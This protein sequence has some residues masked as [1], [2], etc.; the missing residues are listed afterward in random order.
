M[1]S[2]S[3]A[4]TASVPKRQSPSLATG[5]STGQSHLDGFRAMFHL[6]AGE[7][8]LVETWNAFLALRAAERMAELCSFEL[9]TLGKWI[10]RSEEAMATSNEET[11]SS[12]HWGYR[13]QDVLAELQRR[14]PFFSSEDSFKFSC[15]TI[16]ASALIGS[17]EKAASHVVTLQSFPCSQEQSWWALYTYKHVLLSLLRHS[18]PST[19]FEFYL[20]NRIALKRF[21][22]VGYSRGPRSLTSVGGPFFKELSAILRRIS[23]PAILLAQRGSQWDELLI[24]AAGRIMIHV[25]CQDNLAEDALAV[26][27]ELVRQDASV[28]YIHQHILVRA[29][30]KAGSFEHANTL[31]VAIEPKNKADEGEKRSYEST[32]LYLFAHQGDVGRA[33]DAFVRLFERKGVLSQ[34]MNLVMHASAVHG[35]VDRVLELFNAFFPQFSKESQNPVPSSRK[36]EPSVKHYSTVVYAFAQRN[37]F[38]GMNDWIR[39]MMK[40]GYTP[41]IVSFAQRGDISAI[42]SLLTHMYEVGIRP[43]IISYTT[44][45]KLLARRRDIVAAESMYKRMIRDGIVPDRKVITTVMNAYVE[46]GSWKGVIRVF[47]Y[48]RSMPTKHLKLGIDV[49]NTLLKAYVLVGAPLDIVMNI[50]RRLE[51]TNIRPTDRTFA[52]LIQSACDSGRMDVASRLFVEMETLA[53]NWQTNVQITVYALTI[54]MAGY[55]RQGLKAQARAVYDDMRKRGIQPTSYTLSSIMRAYANSNFDDNIHIAQEFLKSLMDAPAKG[56]SWAKP[57]AGRESSLALLYAPLMNAH[58]KNLNTEEVERLYSEFVDSEKRPSI[59]ILA[60]LLDVYRRTDNIKGRT[61]EVDMLLDGKDKESPLFRAQRRA[62]LLCIPLS[63]Y[64]DAVSRAGQHI[65]IAHTWNKLRDAGFQFDAH[66]WNHL[67]V[68]LVRAGQCVRAFEVVE[69]VIL[70]YQTEAQNVSRTRPVD[71]TSPLLSDDAEAVEEAGSEPFT[72]HSSRSYETRARWAQQQRE[73][74]LR[75]Q[76]ESDDYAHELQL[77]QQI[78]PAWNLTMNVL[79]NVLDR[80]GSGRLVN[81][82]KPVSTDRMAEA[83]AEATTKT[84]TGVG[85]QTQQSDSHIKP[86]ATQ[87]LRTEN[88]EVEA[89]HTG[90]RAARAMLDR[91]LRDYPQTNAVREES[92]QRTD[93]QTNRELRNRFGG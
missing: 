18:S 84:R 12:V 23:S 53:E 37:D 56:R 42:H 13:L 16:Q 3:V 44:A 58:A 65:E 80:L 78:S 40:S 7:R 17:F 33:E 67:A 73:N 49:Y 63:I 35:N 54:I 72:V 75:W 92:E 9:F 25:L 85:T 34:E 59:G 47:D 26:Y 89:L 20:D 28:F 30:T 2:R 10:A 11:A 87:P 57:E 71:I 93:K 22:N 68:A 6:P 21:L 88:Q 61:D 66:N 15:L 79:A 48:L 51:T 50:F 70:P 91:I 43:D 45:I 64:I 55:L 1:F 90:E 82:V 77:L 81:A 86:D 24:S 62:D 69:K 76:A 39:Q 38:N 29:L 60:L 31:Y 19:A 83:E 52:L 46:A 8:D 14:R 36:S 41:D 32:G 4:S 74:S 5:A 27:E